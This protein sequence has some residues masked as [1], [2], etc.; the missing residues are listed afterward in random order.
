LP[1]QAAAISCP[2]ASACRVFMILANWPGDRCSRFAHR[3][4][5]DAVFGVAGPAAAPVLAAGHAAAHVA[6]HL[7]RQVHDVEQV[8][9]DPRARQ[10]AAHRGGI[11]RAHAGR[12]HPD[13][14][15]PGGGGL[16]QPVRGVIGGAALHLPQQ[17]L[18]AGQVKEAGMPPVGEQQVLPGLLGLCPA[19]QSSP[20]C[21]EGRRLRHAEEQNIETRADPDRQP[22]LPRSSTTL[23][24]MHFRRLR[25]FSRAELKTRFSIQ[26][27]TVRDI[28]RFQPDPLEGVPAKAIDFLAGQLGIADPSCV[29]AHPQPHPGSLRR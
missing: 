13:G 10:H 9:R 8:H 7:D 6:G 1:I 26:L 15:P 27:A 4:V 14:V 23:S 20:R 25:E 19:S 28:G 24:T 5:L 17:P 21:P 29:G 22:P 3:Q 11:N 2:A 12:D 16:G 18:T